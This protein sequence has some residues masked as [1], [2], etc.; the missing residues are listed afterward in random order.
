[1]KLMV[2][3][4]ALPFADSRV[5]ILHWKQGADGVGVFVG[6]GTVCQDDDC[7]YE[8]DVKRVP[9]ARGI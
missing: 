2:A 6:Q 5:P 9:A 3:D 8:A 7:R 1:M 4:N